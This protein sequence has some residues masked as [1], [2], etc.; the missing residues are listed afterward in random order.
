MC[1]GNDYVTRKY[2][3]DDYEREQREQR[4]VAQRE[5]ER[6]EQLELQRE[7]NRRAAKRTRLAAKRLAAKKKAKRVAA[8][9]KAA[10][11]RKRNK[12]IKA[13]KSKPTLTVILKAKTASVEEPVIKTKSVS[14]AK[15][16]AVR[17]Y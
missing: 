12:K 8:A 1:G 5:V 2:Y 17:M 15:A 14:P 4:R 11:T 7:E 9:L 6:A 3:G 10:A 16:R 13:A